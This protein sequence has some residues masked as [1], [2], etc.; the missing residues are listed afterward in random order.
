M[1]CGA[2][3]ARQSNPRRLFAKAKLLLVETWLFA[4]RE[5]KAKCAQHGEPTGNA[6][7]PAPADHGSCDAIVYANMFPHARNLIDPV[8]HRLSDRQKNLADVFVSRF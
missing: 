7:R 1:S 3:R 2:N 4:R 5:P 8:G 6:Q